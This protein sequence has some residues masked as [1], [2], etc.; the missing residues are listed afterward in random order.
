[1]NNVANAIGP[2][3]GANLVSMNTGIIARRYFYC[4]RCHVSWWRRAANK[5]EKDYEVF[6]YLKGEP[7]QVPVHSCYYRIDLWTPSP[8]YASNQY[9][10]YGD[11][12]W[13]KKAKTQ[14][15]SGVISKIVKVWLVSPVFSLVISYGLMKLFVDND[16]YTVIVLLSV[17]MATFGILS[18]IKTIR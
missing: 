11:W 14:L 18:L 8:T 7:F 2:L 9:S 15:I 10:H 16:L 17:S 3:V 12:T 1:M 4:L 13:Q 6:L 5:C